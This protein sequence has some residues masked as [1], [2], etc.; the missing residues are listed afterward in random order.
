MDRETSVQ[1]PICKR[2]VPVI[3]IRIHEGKRIC[4]SCFTRIKGNEFS[5]PQNKEVAPKEKPKRLAEVSYFC[6]SCNYKFSRPTGF[7]AVHVCP[8]CGKRGTIERQ[9]TASDIITS[10]SQ[11]TDIVDEDEALAAK[12]K[13]VLGY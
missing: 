3:D 2:S 5:I 9:M 7:E 13:R 10:V 8:F 11:Y 6:N 1:C 4:G 12:K